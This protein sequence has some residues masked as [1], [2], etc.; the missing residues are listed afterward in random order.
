MV[1]EVRK[2]H[3]DAVECILG[4]LFAQT[5]IVEVVEVVSEKVVEMFGG[6][7]VL[8]LVGTPGEKTLNCVFVP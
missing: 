3:E 2:M 1:L 5:R 4:H 6:R 7:R 8:V